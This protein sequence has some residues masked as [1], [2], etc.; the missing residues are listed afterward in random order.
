MPFGA[1]WICSLCNFYVARGDY[2]LV[3]DYLCNCFYIPKT[4]PPPVPVLVPRVGA[5]STAPRVRAGPHA[6]P[7][8]TH[9]APL[10]AVDG[11]VVETGASPVKFAQ[12]VCMMGFPERRREP[13]E[14]AFLN[15]H[16]LNC[17]I[18]FFP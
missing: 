17:G 2:G 13:I 5:N 8:S 14:F 9:P 15:I 6:R 16:I 7:R 11:V 1:C 4:R 18:D 12:H 3:H 10:P